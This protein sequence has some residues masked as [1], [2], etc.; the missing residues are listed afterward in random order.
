[1]AGAMA[2]EEEAQ[3]PGAAAS[4]GSRAILSILSDLVAGNE[5]NP[6]DPAVFLAQAVGKC[7]NLATPPRFPHVPA[8]DDL[9]LPGI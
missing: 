8:R 9:C 2:R 6:G 4:R 1:M 3:L 7:R 5:V